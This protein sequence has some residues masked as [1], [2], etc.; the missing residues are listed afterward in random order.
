ME[1]RSDRV[2]ANVLQICDGGLF[3]TNV[4]AEHKTFSYHKTLCGARPYRTDTFGRE[5]NPAY[6]KG[7][8][9]GW[10]YFV[11]LSIAS[12]ALLLSGR[13]FNACLKHLIASSLLFCIK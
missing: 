5:R 7:A 4:D 9:S 13:I 12:F 1:N 8:V 11:H 6:C 2:A 3:S 10:F